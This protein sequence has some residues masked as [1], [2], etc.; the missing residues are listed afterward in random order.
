[1]TIRSIKGRSVLAI[2]TIEFVRQRFWVDSDV[3]TVFWHDHAL[4][5]IT[6]GHGGFDSIIIEP[7][8]YGVNGTFRE[9]MV[10]LNDSVPHTINIVTAGS[11]P[12]QPVEVALEAGR[13]ISFPISDH[14]RTTPMPFLNGETH[15]TGGSLNFLAERISGR[16]AAFL[17]GRAAVW[18][19]C[20]SSS[21]DSGSAHGHSR[22][23][24]GGNRVVSEASGHGRGL[25]R[26]SQC[27]AV[28]T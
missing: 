7:V 2:V 4:G 11:S 24:A 5:R 6:W 27:L 20:R 22:S 17:Q 23:C 1:M 12:G 14:I 13:T 19:Q 10:Q 16:P 18:M 28:R 3:G 26:P 15:T 21:V 8:G 9:L 25:S